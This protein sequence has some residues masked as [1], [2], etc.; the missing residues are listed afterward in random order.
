MS[1]EI[2]KVRTSDDIAAVRTLVWEFFDV[3]KQRYP[4]MHSEIDTYISK[5]N[6]AGELENF[7]AYYLPPKG[8][9][10]M[11]WLDGEPVG[12]VMLKP[13]GTSDGEMNR[14]YVRETA[15]GHGLGRKLGQALVAEARVLGYGAVWLDAID[16]HVE[17]LPLYESLG[18]ERY[19]DPDAFGG[20]D[21]RFVHMKLAL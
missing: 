7:S 6:V 4:E 14:M 21:A 11:A 15:R 19:T 2:T 12:I 16:R 20:E 5:Q 18:F 8:E 13:R 10:F 1:M 9:A 17:A 3:I